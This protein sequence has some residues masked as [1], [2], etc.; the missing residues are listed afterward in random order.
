MKMTGVHPT[1]SPSM[2]I[3]ISSNFERLLYELIGR[4]GAAVAE[5]MLQF[6]GEGEYVL[7]SDVMALLR[8]HWSGERVDDEQTKKII[9]TTLEN[10]HVLVD[11]HTAVG[12]G[13]AVMCRRLAEPVICLSTA[14]PAKFPDAVEAATG[15]RPELPER[16]R[17]LADRP[18]HFDVLPNDLDAVRSAIDADLG[19]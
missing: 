4:D 3:Q 6:R 9:A 15:V 7:G 11:P 1:L 2:D 10:S 17:D 16:L 13:A 18:E 19:Q 14:H 8:E 12:L 5:L